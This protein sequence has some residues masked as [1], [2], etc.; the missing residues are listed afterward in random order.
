MAKIKI[1]TSKPIPKWKV[2]KIKIKPVKRER[3]YT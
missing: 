2:I 3:K 1:T